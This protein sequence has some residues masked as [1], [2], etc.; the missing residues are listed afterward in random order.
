MCLAGTIRG[1]HN[2]PPHCHSTQWYAGV[3]AG[4]SIRAA[5]SARDLHARKIHAYGI[6]PHKGGMPIRCTPNIHAY[7][8]HAYGIHAYAMD[9]H[10][11][12]T[13]G[14]HARKYIPMG[15]TPMVCTPVRYT[16]ISCTPIR[17]AP[18]IYTPMRY[19]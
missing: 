18:M 9:A 3:G 14:M 4:G 2:T 8:I 13:C 15:C 19:C 1:H 16:P 7:W 11:I 17:C 10:E 12:R 5:I 6:L